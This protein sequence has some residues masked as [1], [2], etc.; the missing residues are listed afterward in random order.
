MATIEDLKGRLDIRD[1]WRVLGCEGEPSKSCR[2]PMR[3]DSKPSFSVYDE[4]R[5]FQDFGGSGARGD[6]LDFI[7][8]VKGTDLRGALEWARDYL[9][10]ENEA[11]PRRDEARP[12][13]TKRGG[14]PW[15]EL[16]A[17]TDAD[18]AALAELRT[19]WAGSL[20]LAASRGFLHFG[21]LWGFPFWGLTDSRRQLVE[22]RR[23]DGHPWPAFGRLS[24]RKAHCIG[25]GKSWPLGIAE[26]QAFSRIALVEGS[27]DFLAFHEIANVEGKLDRVG[28]VAMLGGASRIAPEAAAMLAGKEVWLYPHADNAG[29]AAAVEWARTLI[30]AGVRVKRFDLAGLVKCDGTAG[31][32]L[33]D[34]ILI[35]PECAK[36]DAKWREILP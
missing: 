30:Q 19:I 9:G 20:Q 36:S 17:G 32:D 4:G 21:A 16:R 1:L 26:A 22:L 8:L 3:P 23:M 11:V 27:P 12:R 25:S 7:A 18:F 2:A 14:A 13:E 34:Y 31:K 5:R 35:S 28:I 10:V 24:E 6:A 33:N 15:P 29:D